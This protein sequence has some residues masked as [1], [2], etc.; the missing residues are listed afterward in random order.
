MMVAKSW[1][2]VATVTKEGS[3]IRLVDSDWSFLR[4]MSQ[5]SDWSGC[6]AGLLV[7]M[8]RDQKVWNKDSFREKVY[9]VNKQNRK[10]D[11]VWTHR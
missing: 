1:T 7:L 10:Q 3:L 9:F 2:G 5:I 6:F 11:A 4:R 8:E